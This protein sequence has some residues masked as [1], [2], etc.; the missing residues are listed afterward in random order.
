MSLDKRIT[1][2]ANTVTSKYVTMETTLNAQTATITASR[3]MITSA[4]NAHVIAFGTNPNL[5]TATNCMI[6]PA[7]Q[8][9]LFNFVS[10]EKIAVKCI[11]AGGGHVTIVDM[12]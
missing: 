4:V 10:G 5:T 12:D 7:N 11:T 3:I 8:T 2:Y 1:L 9:L 6:I